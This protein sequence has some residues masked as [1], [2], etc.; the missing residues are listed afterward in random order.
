MIVSNGLLVLSRVGWCDIQPPGEED[1][2]TK[3]DSTCT[4][5]LRVEPQ[6]NFGYSFTLLVELLRPHPPWTIHWTTFYST[7]LPSA[8]FQVRVKCPFNCGSNTNPTGLELILPHVIWSTLGLD[9]P[10]NGCDISHCIP[11]S[12]VGDYTVCSNWLHPTQV[13]GIE[14]FVWEA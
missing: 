11:L 4:K 8:G 14:S 7:I 9:H 13:G 3:C 2:G 10:L 5:T 6:C 1:L 12:T